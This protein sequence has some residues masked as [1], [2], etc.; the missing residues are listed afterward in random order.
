MEDVHYKRASNKLW[1]VSGEAGQ[2]IRVLGKGLW[3]LSYYLGKFID[4]ALGSSVVRKV[5]ED[6]RGGRLCPKIREVQVGLH[7]LFLSNGVRISN[8]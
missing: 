1:L 8:L 6:K 4:Y 7:D 5:I 2:R 3:G